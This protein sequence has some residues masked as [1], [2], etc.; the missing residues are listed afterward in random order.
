MNCET[1]QQLLNEMTASDLADLDHTV[2]AHTQKCETCGHVLR[3]RTLTS[4]SLASTRDRV[5]ASPEFRRSL[6]DA[7]D[8]EAASLATAR[9]AEPRKKPS[10]WQFL[11][12]P[13]PVWAAAALVLVLVSGFNYM[14]T[15]GYLLPAGETPADMAV[16]V[17]DVGHDAFLY[18]R[19]S[20]TLEI[21]TGDPAAVRDW[22][23]PRL[24]FPVNAPAALPGGYSM[25]GARLWHTVARLSAFVSYTSADGDKISLFVISAHNLAGTGAR[26]IER[27]GRTYHA[28]KSFQFNVVSWQQGG[29]A[30]A[31]VG[32]IPIDTLLEIA[33]GYSL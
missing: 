4:E 14:R 20:Q 29:A 33:A 3:L 9:T 23:A 32:K 24:D 28:G 21:E 25:Q 1:V 5:Q 26:E 18:A 19:H 7:I 11:F 17:H 8:R 10:F 22:F 27:G 31:L 6:L 13:S 16:F 30:Y 2:R 15:M 12:R